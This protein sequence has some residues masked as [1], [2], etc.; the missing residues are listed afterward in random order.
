[1]KGGAENYHF[2]EGG[3]VIIVDHLGLPLGA[4]QRVGFQARDHVDVR[5]GPICLSLHLKK[6]ISKKYIFGFFINTV[7]IH[8]IFKR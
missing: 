2:V 1:M 4:V 6:Y 5:V 8:F 3:V 7:F